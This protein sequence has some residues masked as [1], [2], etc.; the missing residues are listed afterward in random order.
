MQE[1]VA[2]VAHA[3]FIVIDDGFKHRQPIFDG[4]QLIDLLLILNDGEA[5]FGM[6]KGEVNLS[7]NRIL[8]N[9]N[10]DRAQRLGHAHGPV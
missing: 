4:E 2:V 6:L 9:W 8:I 5:H 7:G 1:A 3:A 10:R